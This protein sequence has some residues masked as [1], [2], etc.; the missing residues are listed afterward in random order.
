MGAAGM[1]GSAGACAAARAGL[2]RIYEIVT[3]E[4]ALTNSGGEQPTDMKTDVCFEDVDFSY[5]SRPDQM[6]FVG[7]S[8]SVPA[9]STAAF[10]GPS[11]TG[12]STILGL[13][14]RFYNTSKGRVPVGG[15]DLSTLDASWFRR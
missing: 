6:I 15:R 8:F 11:G 3:R 9:Q 7:L 14:S 13:L 12:K 2:Q 1:A 4:P 5:P 10:V